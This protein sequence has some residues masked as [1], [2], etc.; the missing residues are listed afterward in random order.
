MSKSL[1]ELFDRKCAEADDLAALVRELLDALVLH[2]PNDG[3]LEL[4][5]HAR[6]RAA[7]EGK[8]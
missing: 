7:L 6:A 3:D 8:P 2:Y 1:D 5:A 4:I